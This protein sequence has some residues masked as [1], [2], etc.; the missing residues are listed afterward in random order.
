MTE[1]ELQAIETEL[2]KRG[3][4]KHTATLTSTET[5]AWFK[6][7][8]KEKD[9][10]GHVISGYL[11][12]FRVWDLRQYIHRDPH[13]HPYGFDYWT[14]PLGTDFRTDFT[15]NWEPFCDIDIFEKMAKEFDQ[16]IRKTYQ[17][18]PI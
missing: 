17:T 8:G 4:K 2:T 9:D 7:F 16:L 11:I 3:Y 18:N 13:M 15:S 5:Y 1:K 12:A 6:T 10:D 14:S